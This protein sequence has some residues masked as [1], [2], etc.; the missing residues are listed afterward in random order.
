M[1]Q[2]CPSIAIPAHPKPDKPATATGNIAQFLGLI[3]RAGLERSLLDLE[4]EAMEGLKDD[5]YALEACY[6]LLIRTVLKRGRISATLPKRLLIPSGRRSGPRR[7]AVV[8]KESFQ[9]IRVRLFESLRGLA[10][11]RLCIQPPAD[12]VFDDWPD[13]ERARRERIYTLQ[14]DR[15]ERIISGW[16]TPDKYRHGCSARRARCSAGSFA[17]A[18][19]AAEW[20]SL[21][22]GRTVLGSAI[23][24]AIKRGFKCAGFHWNYDDDSSPGPIGGSKAVS[25][26]ELDVDFASLSLA[27]E[28]AG[29]TTN[30]M[31]RCLRAGGGRMVLGPNAQNAMAGHVLTFVLAG[32]SETPSK[33]AGLFDVALAG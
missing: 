7:G 4:D 10:T 30:K 28:F 12:V 16:S 14:V 23:R 15:L 6:R 32:T 19:K 9:T 17:S 25:C 11:A 21:Q 31:S 8:S 1:P 27:A 29:C 13:L 22:S 18:N 26:V 5:I 2:L 20:A 24:T 33:I 3:P